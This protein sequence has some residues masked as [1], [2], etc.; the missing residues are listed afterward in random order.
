MKI[1]DL[2]VKRP[3]VYGWFGFQRFLLWLF[4]FLGIFFF[5]NTLYIFA[6]G[7]V[8]YF[9]IDEM[10]QEIARK[11]N[12]SQRE[13]KQLLINYFDP[14]KYKPILYS[15][16]LSTSFFIIARYSQKVINRNRYILQLEAAVRNEKEKI[17]FP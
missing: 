16:S 8:K 5:F 11:F 7:L 15:F 14:I 4:I 1:E 12:V 2:I 17:T 3:R 10:S 9:F 13:V 6:C